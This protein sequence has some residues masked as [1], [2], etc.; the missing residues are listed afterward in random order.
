MMDILQFIKEIAL[1]SRY[2]LRSLNE[3]LNKSRK[4]QV[5]YESFYR[6]LKNRTIKY[7]E[8]ERIADQLGY[9]IVWKKKE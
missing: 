6:Q 5:M 8:M 3:Y 4:N 1:S 9:E 7:T 2:S